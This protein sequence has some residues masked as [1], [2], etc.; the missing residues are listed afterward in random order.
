MPEGDTVHLAA[1]RLHDAFAGHVLERAELRVPRLATVDLRGRTVERVEARGKHLLIRL[2]DDLTLHTHFKME[3]SWK[4]ARG[5][6]SVGASRDD[7]R[8]VLGTATTTAIGLRLAIVEVWPG[9]REASILGHLG[10]DPLRDDWDADEAL[11]RFVAAGTREVGEVLLDQS[12]IAGPGNVYKSEICFLRGLHPRASVS[13]ITRPE[14][15][16]GLT[17]RLMRANR[18]TGRQITTGDTR[19]GRSQWVY[20]RTGKPC[21]RCGT[22]IE[23][24]MQEARGAL[25]ERATYLCPT[26]QP[27]AGTRPGSGLGG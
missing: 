9:E 10:P 20:G 17:C 8:A 12:V 16:V 15:V 5:T 7:V 21:L 27:S 26:C 24:I 11:R 1:T 2:S 22:P 18:K 13:S 3:G 6:A 23:M 25:D 4:I 14:L 19:R